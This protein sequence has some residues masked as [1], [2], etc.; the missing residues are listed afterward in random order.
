MAE[1]NDESAQR[2]PLRP[3][4]TGESAGFTH[5]TFGYKRVGK[6]FGVYKEI[7]VARAP[8]CARCGAPY[9]GKIRAFLDRLVAFGGSTG[10][11]LL[12]PNGT[13]PPQ[14]PKDFPEQAEFNETE[15]LPES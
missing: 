5:A 8:P 7:G 6:K 10:G 4:R 3:K 2:T 9:T 13:P 1:D 14:I 15:I 11:F 12:E